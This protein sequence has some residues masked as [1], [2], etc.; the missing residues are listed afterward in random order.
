VFR[1]AEFGLDATLLAGTATAGWFATRYARR[2]FVAG[3]AVSLLALVTG[4]LFEVRL[5]PW[6]D[7]LVFLFALSGGSLLASLLP[8]RSAPQGLVLATLSAIDIG[9][10]L[11]PTPVATASPAQLPAP[12][13]F[14]NVVLLLPHG[15]RFVLGALDLLLAAALAAQARR[16]RRS[17]LT[18][19]APTVIGIAL[20]FLVVA[21]RPTPGLPLIPFFSTVWLA[22]EIAGRLV[23]RRTCRAGD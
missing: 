16:R 4:A 7:G 12:F 8:A 6:T 22:L 18:G 13:F 9:L 11:L 17:F 19:T 1:L 23:S 10:I 14:G 21:L 2:W 20:A 3:T 15:Q 5:Y